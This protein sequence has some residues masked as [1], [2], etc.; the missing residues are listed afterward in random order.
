MSISTFFKNLFG[1]IPEVEIHVLHPC[2]GKHIVRQA[3]TMRIGMLEKNTAFILFD[4]DIIYIKIEDIPVTSGVKRSIC[5][6]YK[7][8]E[9]KLS[10]VVLEA[11]SKVKPLSEDI[12]LCI[13]ASGYSYD[14][15]KDSKKE[16]GL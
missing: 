15:T 14:R 7:V 11:N 2:E 10:V 5:A 8:K 9:S 6:R 13:K 16:G 1:R 12:T 3:R 4:K